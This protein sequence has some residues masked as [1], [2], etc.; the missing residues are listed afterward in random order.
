MNAIALVLVACLPHSAQCTSQVQH[1][2]P[3]SHEEC[4]RR[5][6]ELQKSLAGTMDDSGYRPLQVICIY[7]DSEQDAK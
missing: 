4:T 5:A 1:P 2:S 7:G 6:A 3:Q